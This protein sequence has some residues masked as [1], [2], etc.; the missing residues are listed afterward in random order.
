MLVRQYLRSEGLESPLNEYRILTSWQE[1][2]GSMVE[3]YTGR[4]YIR[5]EKLHVEIKS[6]SLRADLM[7]QRTEL[8]NKLNQYVGATV[9]NDII[10]L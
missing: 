2:T 4:L 3:R 8:V 7:L 10:F 6:P 9:I 5:N 1:V